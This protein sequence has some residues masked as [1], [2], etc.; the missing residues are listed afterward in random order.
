MILIIVIIITSGSCPVGSLTTHHHSVHDSDYN[1]LIP[2]VDKSNVEPSKGIFWNLITKL[3]SG[4][5]LLIYSRNRHG[6]NK[7]QIVSKL[8]YL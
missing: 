5:S 6:L 2:Q 4:S 7:N 8:I 3:L 1:H